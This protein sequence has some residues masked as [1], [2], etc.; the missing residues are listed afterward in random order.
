MIVR[1]ILRFSAAANQ[2]CGECVPDCDAEGLVLQK[3]RIY[4]LTHCVVL[5]GGLL[6][7]AHI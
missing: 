7:T 2:V 6:Q 1:S 3:S 4:P 5:A